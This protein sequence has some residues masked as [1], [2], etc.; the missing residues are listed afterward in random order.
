MIDENKLR[1]IL[2]KARR[3][4]PSIT[5]D[6][7][8][9]YDLGGVDCPI[10]GNKGYI[11]TRKD[12][13]NLTSRECPCMETR[14]SLRAIRRSGMADML[15]RYRLDN[16]QTP[17][18][19]SKS[20]KQSAIDFI[21]SPSGWFFICGR[22]GSGKTH[23]CTAICSEFIQK[24]IRTIYMLWRDEATSL[25]SGITDREWYRDR[26][27]KLKTVPVL[28]IDDFWKTD[29]RSGTDKVT[30]A[31]VNLAFEILNARYNDT[32][33]RTVISSELTLDEI[34]SIDE[35]TGGRIYERSRGFVK[36]APQKNWRLT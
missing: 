11:I 22:S 2:E 14:R 10:C 25:K 1:K 5:I 26:I 24:G 15:D 31:D 28:Y 9:D 18:E 30:G 27:T 20:V 36:K 33:L 8:D 4:T 19:E 21:G 34:I 16:Y 3:E 12:G 35:A 23:I 7:L 32:T 29:R 6:T 17:D 13:I